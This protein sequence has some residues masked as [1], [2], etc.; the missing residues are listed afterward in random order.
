MLVSLSAGAAAIALDSEGGGSL[1][2]HLDTGVV[3]HQAPPLSLVADGV[4]VDRFLSARVEATSEGAALVGEVAPG[5]VARLTVRPVGPSGCFEFALG[6]SNSGDRPI[7]ITRADSLAVTALASLSDA[8]AYTSRWGDEYQPIPFTVTE[9]RVIDVRS[10]RSA[11]G[12]SPFLALSGPATLAVAPVWSGNWHISLDPGPDGI[13]V[14]AG[15]NPWKFEHILQPGRTFEAPEVLLA[16]GGDLEEATL[17]L[18][19]AVG[20]TLPRTA[21]TEAIPLEWNHWWPYEDKDITEEIFL[22]NARLATELGFVT[23]TLDAGWFGAPDPDTFWWDI[24][25]DFA[26][27]N[28]ARFPGGIG[29]LGAETRKRGQKFGIWEEWEAVGLKAEIRRS[30]PDLM[31]RRDDDPPE[32]PLDKEDPGFLGYICL[33]S[34]AGRAHLRGLIEDLVAKT[35]CE[36]IKLDFNL[37][38]KAGCSAPGH[39]HGPGDGLYAHY[40]GLYQVL[41][42]FRAAHPEVV[43]EACASG[44]LRIDAGLMRHLHCAFLSDPDWTPHHLQVV[45]GTSH[46][47]PPAAM[48]HWPMSEW[49]GKHTN[50]TLSLRDPALTADQFDAILR[51]GF[52]HR[53]GL[54]WRL[55]DLP[56][57]WRVRLKAHLDHYRTHVA[58][59]VRDG[60]LRRLSGTP[61][62]RGG[63]E[64]LP[65]FQLSSGDTHLLLGFALEPAAEG[66]CIRPQE[67]G[68]V[69]K[70]R[71]LDPDRTYQLVSLAADGSTPVLGQKSGAA[72]MDEGL[73]RV[74]ESS[75]AGLLTAV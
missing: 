33:G 63:G 70:P 4:T 64:P 10:G 9:P 21:A 42:E 32:E 17:A 48:L 1:S 6:L 20:A 28:R 8:L 57:H 69:L 51:S 34:E 26:S 7:A 25:G 49:R 62:R 11:L 71:A 68:F 37:D 23:S 43:V 13:R 73:P 27:E 53:F 5:L 61:L 35:G 40:R 45:H 59:L 30:R 44:G 15:L 67:G 29:H 60:D 55:P 39:D 36:W 2:V 18:T 16:L 50:Q 22:E 52:M 12:H 72:W 38:P 56:E 19:R 3:L 24:R 66:L 14:T 46:L 75:F 31:A 65:A 58:P 54:S 47:M 41:D 74:F